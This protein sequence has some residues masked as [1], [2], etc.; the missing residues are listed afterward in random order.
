MR[1]PRSL[2]EELQ[3]SK[4]FDSPA[5]EAVVA[6]MRTAALVR[7]AIAQRVEP[8]GISLAQYNVLRILRGAGEA[9][10]PTLALRDRLI[11]EAPGITRL[12]DKLEDAGYVRRDRTG[13]DRRVVHCC[14][15]EEGLHLLD[16]MEALIK[17]TTALVSKGLPDVEEQQRLVDLLARVRDGLAAPERSPPG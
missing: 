10:L 1:N 14:I 7:R 4:P 8:F 15:T 2:Q 16:A 6:L 3:Q 17:E 9:G 13:G 5:D 11:E 12:V